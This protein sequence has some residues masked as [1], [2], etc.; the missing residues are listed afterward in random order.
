M[1]RIIVTLM[2]CSIIL[3]ILTG[4]VQ[5]SHA[6]PANEFPFPL[7]SQIP[8]DV[9]N[10]KLQKFIKDQEFAKAQRLF[11]LNSWQTF[12]ALN[13]PLDDSRQPLPDITDKGTP[14]WETWKESS[15]VFLPDGSAPAPWG[16]PREVPKKCDIQKP[17][18]NARII[19]LT[20]SVAGIPNDINEVNEAFSYPLWD[21]NGKK[22]RYEIFLNE[23]EFNYI[24]S[25]AY[26]YELYNL[27][28]QIAYAQANGG[29]KAKLDFPSGTNGTDTVGAMEL[30][31]AW[32]VMGNND[33]KERFY[34]QDAYIIDENDD[35]T[36]KSC[37]KETV[38]LVGMHI[39]H[40]TKSSPQWIW[41]TFEQ[42]DNVR[43][44]A[45][46]SD[47]P[48]QPS[49]YNPNNP[50]QPV[51]V[52]PG[53]LNSTGTCDNPN[54]NPTQ[55][56]RVIPIPKDKEVLNH[57]V[58]KGLKAKN[59]VLQYYELIDTQW[60]TQ[61]TKAPTPGGNLP[62]SIT[63]KS[64]GF[65]TPV[66]LTNSIMETYFQIGNQQACQQEEGGCS[67]NP[68]D[69]TQ[70]FGTESC[71]G[72]HSSAGLASGGNQKDGATFNGQLSSD[73]SWLLQKKAHWAKNVA[74]HSFLIHNQ[75][76]QN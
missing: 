40:K 54:N 31:L 51:N 49:F 43:V 62:D 72:C 52:C 27:D 63:N 28:G 14:Q 34:T 29:S 66:Y 76:I 18:D 8:N 23:D 36:V 73:F 69:T 17:G 13:W 46:D 30:K 22:A 42:V 60:P 16:T 39:A 9:N 53:T 57:R 21:Q 1:R 15:E 20:S 7:S 58:Q 44:N 3:F 67:G 4:Y 5:V 56:T 55:V 6:Q 68:N 32:K 25:P 10:N 64:G 24:V 75:F 70:V 2:V 41:S 45:L 59:S 19:S 50:T 38:G 26:G 11:D 74:S 33:K 47:A 65:P 35:G 12:L 61:P 48:A 37:I 71:M